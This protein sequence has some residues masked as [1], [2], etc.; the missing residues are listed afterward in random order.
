MMPAK[1]SLERVA[2]TKNEALRKLMFNYDD[3]S[4]GEKKPK[5]TAAL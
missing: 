5:E 2:I 4:D 1:A 3:D